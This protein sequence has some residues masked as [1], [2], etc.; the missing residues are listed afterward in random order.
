MLLMARFIPLLVS[1]VSA[2]AHLSCATANEGFEIVFDCGGELISAVPFASFGTPR[3][4]CDAG[5]GEANFQ[6]VAECHAAISMASVEDK[7][8]GQST[9]MFIVGA[10]Q[11]GGA[12]KCKAAQTSKRWLSATL[13]CGDVRSGKE[14]DGTGWGAGGQFIFF[15]FFSFALYFALGIAY[16]VKRF[17]AKGLDA[18]PHLEMWLDLPYLV[19]DGVIFSI[20]TLKS[21]GRPNYEAVL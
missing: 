2:A 20:D 15:V 1:S 11:F 10:D 7:C 5:T 3:G 8:L 4:S 17:G 6:V 14:L 16:K 9:C 18:I 21:K 13:A 19:R 12:P